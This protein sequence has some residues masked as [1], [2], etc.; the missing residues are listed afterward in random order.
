MARCVIPQCYQTSQQ[1]AMEIEGMPSMGWKVDLKEFFCPCN[2]WFKY[3]MCVHVIAGAQALNIPLP[4]ESI[5]KAKF[6]NRR[7]LRKGRPGNPGPA[8]SP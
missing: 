3:A 2:A 7:R 5:K 1:M 4:G 8:L 6:Y